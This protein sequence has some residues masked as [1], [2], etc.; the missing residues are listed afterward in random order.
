MALGGEERVLG[1]EITITTASA[2]RGYYSVYTT[3]CYEYFILS[4]WFIH[5]QRNDLL[6]YGIVQGIFFSPVKFD[7]CCFHCYFCKVWGL[8]SVFGV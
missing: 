1:E 5:V 3:N 4:L 6:P 2:K 7:C 8:Y